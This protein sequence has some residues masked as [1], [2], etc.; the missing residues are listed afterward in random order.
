MTPNILFAAT[1][2]GPLWAPAM[3]SWLAA[4]GYANRHFPVESAPLI[5]GLNPRRGGIVANAISDRMYTMS[6]E[7]AL[8]ANALQADPII[9]HIFLTECDMVLPHDVIPKLL[10][11]EKPVVSG[12]YFLRNGNGQPCLYVKGFVNKEMPYSHQPVAIFPE[13]AP[14]ALDP[15]GHGGCVGLGCVLIRRE[16]FEAVPYPWF[17]LK[18][19]NYGSDMYFWTKVRDAGIDVWVHPGVACGQIDYTMMT[20]EDYH[21]RIQEDPKYAS[22]GFIIGTGGAHQPRGSVVR[23]DPTARRSRERGEAV[24]GLGAG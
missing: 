10:E 18:E 6:A 5:P 2:Y 8:V 13:D 3:E 17:D 7:N 15:K 24:A 4:V 14:F 16:V 1:N 21:R 22:S 9:S 23:Y 11:V 19:G 12:V 20:I